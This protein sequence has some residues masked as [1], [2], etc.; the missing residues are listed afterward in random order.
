MFTH[1][2]DN[3][4]Y[5]KLLQ[6]NDAEDLFSLIDRN[7]E[8][9]RKWL[10]WVD[11]VKSVEDTNNSIEKTLKQFANNQSFRAGIFYKEELAGVINFHQIDWTNKKTSIGYW[12]GNEYQGKGLMTKAARAFINHAFSDLKL[13]RVEVRCAVGNSKSRAIP[14][15]L[16]FTNEGTMREAEYLYGHFVDQTIY[17]MTRNEWQNK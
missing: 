3:D 14:E 2:I 17:G 13:H 7:R 8:H 9:L 4:C 5:L 16:G 6:K 12:L 10:S 1:Q 15:K 11:N